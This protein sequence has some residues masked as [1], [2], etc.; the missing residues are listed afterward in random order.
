MV[1][2]ETVEG[3]EG[4][5]DRRRRDED[6][7]DEIAK[8]SGEEQSLRTVGPSGGAARRHPRYRPQDSP[9]PLPQRRTIR[10]SSEEAA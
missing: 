5:A 4:A 2:E 10:R 9:D 7:E 8:Q 1:G 3:R 6:A